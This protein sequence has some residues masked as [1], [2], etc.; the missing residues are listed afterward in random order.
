M[1]R[2]LRVLFLVAIVAA[3]VFSGLN[4]HFILMDQSIKVLKKAF[5]GL[6]YT[7]VDARGAKRLR[8][9]TNAKL[10]RA[11]IRDLLEGRSVTIGQ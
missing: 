4:Y 1:M 5:P 8:L 9:Y 3:V 10:I 6:R 7:F 2:S 11:G